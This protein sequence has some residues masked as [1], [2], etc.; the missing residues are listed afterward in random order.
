MSIRVALNHRTTYEYD[1]LVAI[2]PQIV[3]LRPAPHCRTRIVSYSLKALPKKQFVNWQQD[4]HGNFLARFVFPDKAREFSIEVDLVAEMTVINP[5][6]FF[7]E[8][9]AEHYPFRY[10]P[11][12]AEELK[13]FLA[14]LPVERRLRDLLD[15]LNRVNTRSV[16]FLVGL[17]RAVHERI[18]YVIRMDPGVQTPQQTLTV[19][20]GSCRDSAWLLV[21]M[22]RNLGIAA[23]FVSGYLIQL[24]A[25]VSPLDGPAGPDRDFTDLHA[26]AE[27]YLPGAGW[28]GLDPTSG[29]LAGEGHIPLACTPEPASAAPV[30]GT[31][32]P[33][34]SKFG[35]TMTVSRIH[36]DPRVTKPYSEEQW[37]E[38]ESLGHSV[39]G[40]L[41]AGA[42]RLTMGGEPTFVSIDDMDG[43]EWNTTAVGPNKRKLAADLI[44]RLQRR[45]APGGLLHHGQGKW[46]PGES[47]P[48]WAFSCF[49]RRD[50]EPIWSDI[51][52]I[53][54]ERED[55][56]YGPKEAQQFVSTVARRLGVSP[57]LAIP[58]YEDV[59]HYLWNERRLPT[60][61]DQ[62]ESKLDDPEDRA[63]LAKV[64]QQGLDHVVG[65]ALPLR[66]ERTPEESRW[67]SSPW[68]FRREHM[69]LSPGDSP[70]G[71]RLPLDS[72]PWSAPGDQQY[73][74]P[75]DPFAPRGPLPKTSDCGPTRQAFHSGTLPEPAAI[76][77]HLL[78]PN[79]HRERTPAQ[80]VRLSAVRGSLATSATL[81]ATEIDVSEVGEMN[82]NG[83][84][85]VGQRQPS[86]RAD[87]DTAVG[88]SA[89]GIVRTALCVQP[90]NGRLHVFMPPVIELE[91]Y[92]ELVTAVEATAAELSLPVM[93]EGYPP[94]HD[95]RLN[96]LK[97]T[98][99]PGVIEVNVHPVHNWDELVKITT[100]LYHDARQTRLGTEKF[101][102][103]GRHTG[104]GGGNHVVLGGPTPADS[105][106]LRR[107]DLLRSLVA[108]W[109]NHPS[110]SYLF[111]GIF[112]GPTS[113]SPRVDEARHESLYDLEI[114]FNQIPDPT[115]LLGHQIGNAG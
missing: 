61:V 11:W 86:V 69:F 108:Y 87:D 24:A 83:H 76:G 31:V 60:N 89:T 78:T 7:L 75:L 26:W 56:G 70:M 103:D 8:P 42:V 72:L 36:E 113:Q 94:P 43:A 114:A 30:F 27:V 96:H 67:V 79:A 55:Y 12:L 102:L 22:L 57:E 80:A 16:E 2:F 38:I 50:G 21:Q 112:V 107:P 45:F 20:S 105:P 71:F 35:F 68:L 85:V 97:V 49:W 32:E 106:F 64:F 33:C 28:I 6:D 92:L 3:R 23:R 62:L 25:D 46:Y 15:E 98:P 99:D 4:P 17:N 73:G 101:M 39:D 93:I 100:G 10:E 13:P 104:T 1:R 19:G 9:S 88:R 66:P 90:R 81:S 5:F 59:W 53:A 29:L 84:V 111:S 77:S 37:R 65:Y 34:E 95:Q 52:L 82:G 48:R 51:G 41:E 18:K 54:D 44:R 115:G 40:E 109:N 91:D 47:L 74:E 110:L 14:T 58:A 63:R